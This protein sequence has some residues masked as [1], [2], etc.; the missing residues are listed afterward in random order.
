MQA[1]CQLNFPGKYQNK[2]G[3]F[4]SRGAVIK[5]TNHTTEH[6]MGHFVELDE[7]HL[8]NI[9]LRSRELNGVIPS[10]LCIFLQRK[11]YQAISRSHPFTF[12]FSAFTCILFLL[13][14]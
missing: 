1:G 14:V 6:S 9:S 5:K 10:M 3:N 7:T 8:I 2:S 4:Y 11:N 12:I 13:K